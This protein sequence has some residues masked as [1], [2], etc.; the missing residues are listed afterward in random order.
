M[1]LYS[2]GFQPGKRTSLEE[3]KS[4]FRGSKQE[5]IEEVEI[6]Q[7]QF[8]LQLLFTR[9]VNLRPVY[10]IPGSGFPGILDL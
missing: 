7:G 8:L 1:T 5:L 10:T 6:M 9:V 3:V 4:H 2:C